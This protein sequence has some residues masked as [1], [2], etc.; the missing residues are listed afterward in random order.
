MDFARNEVTKQSPDNITK[1][2]NMHLMRF[3]SII[4]LFTFCGIVSLISCETTSIVPIR[5]YDPPKIKLPDTA[6]NITLVNRLYIPTGTESYDKKSRIDSL[7]VNNIAQNKLFEGIED[8]LYSLEL[9]DTVTIV[10]KTR[11]N[12]DLSNTYNELKPLSWDTIGAISARNGSDMLISLDGLNI[13]PVYSS[14]SP[15]SLGADFNTLF[16]KIG[17]LNVYLS[18]LFRIYDPE[19]KH[20]IEE[21]HYIDTIFW[22]SEGTTHNSAL[23]NL[24]LKKDAVS[25]AAYWSGI[26]YTERFMS[27]WEEVDRF[28]YIRGHPDLKKAAILVKEEK[29]LDA[30]K[31]WKVLAYGP[32]N[33][34]A[35]RAAL[36]MALVSEMNDNLDAALNWAIES[37]SLN[38]KESVEQYLKVLL[39]RIRIYKK[40]L[41]A[42]E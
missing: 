39:E 1:M 5:V 7:A 21:H 28:Y 20:L 34:I 37:Y 4:Y 32:D 11:K 33:E 8:A 30:T 18:A 36:N 25:E 38:K 42:E 23:R 6:C 16:Y 29:W 14:A 24:H 40:Y 3:R 13:T 15:Y 12:E 22:E 31:I 9:V 41:W 19:K 10:Q 26:N 35:S 27:R 2:S 17:K